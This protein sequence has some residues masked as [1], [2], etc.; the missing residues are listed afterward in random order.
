M[1]LSA[2]Y[3][4]TETT[5]F[6]SPGKILFSFIHLK[7]IFS[8]RSFNSKVYLLM[9]YSDNNSYKTKSFCWPINFSLLYDSLITET[10]LLISCHG[11]HI[12]HQQPNKTKDILF[13]TLKIGDTE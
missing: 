3:G 2:S 4:N 8:N 1:Q 11:K 6:G 12:F 9:V 13:I 5:T 7:H 10:V